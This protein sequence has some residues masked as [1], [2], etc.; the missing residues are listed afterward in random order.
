MKAPIYLF[1]V[2]F[3]FCE[4]LLSQNQ[5]NFITDNPPRVK[6]YSSYLIGN[7]VY[8][9]CDQNIVFKTPDAGESFE[10]LSPYGPVNNSSLGCCDKH[11][12]AFAD[13][14]I[15]Y[16]TDAAHG[17]FRTVDGGRT[18]SKKAHSGSN[19]SL[20][21]FGSTAVGWKVGEGGLYKTTNAG[22][23]WD[24]IGA[25]FFGAGIF[26]NI[27][28]LDNQNVWILK[29]YYR[30]RNVEGSIWYSS[31]GGSTWSQ[32]QSGLVSSDENQIVYNDM[33]MKSS[34]EGIAIGRISRPS[35]NEKRSFIQRTT[36]FGATW[37]TTELPDN[38]LND[39]LY[40]DDSTWVILGNTGNHP[41]NDLV[42]LR[43]EDNGQSWDESIP[44]SYS[45]YNYLYSSIY[46]PGYESILV[47]TLSG[48]YKS[49][50]KGRTYFRITTDYDIYI[51][52]VLL[53][54]KPLSNE[55]QTIIAKSFNR[56]YLLSRDAGRS[57]ELKEIPGEI[58]NI[59][60]KVKIAEEVIYI[61]VDQTRLYKSI[62]YG[63]TWSR[64]YVPLYWS[65]LRAL[66]VLDQNTLLVQGYPSLCTSFDGGANWIASPFP[67]SFWL[68]E[69]VIL[70]SNQIVAVGG[71]YKSGT[72]GIFYKSPDNGF[73]WRIED[74]PHEM[75]QIS[76]ITSKVGFA[77]NAR[78]LYKTIDGGD[79]WMMIKTSNDYYD[80]FSA[81]CFKDAL[82]GLLYSGES[83]LRT[84]DGG[85]NWQTVELNFPFSYVDKLAVNNQGDLFA[86][87]GG[88]F[89]VY[90][91]SGLLKGKADSANT[92]KTLANQFVLLQNTPNPFNIET[93]IPLFVSREG[94]V[95]L[96]IYDILG[97]KVRA[98]FSGFL[99]SGKHYF[100]W[101]GVDDSGFELSSGIYIYRVTYNEGSSFAK[102]MILIK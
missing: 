4:S 78:N 17:E 75:E 53:D 2:I 7:T 59:L 39:V 69:S 62:D 41:D 56:S 29:S 49:I 92:S 64:V 86:V 10:V 80:A 97:Q 88:N 82:N 23:S 65:A 11:G 98:L 79:S 58:G 95:T 16:I 46:L 27:Y 22:E 8:F 52:D 83:F 87:S 66:D 67:G 42:Q 60:W 61:V 96:K 15:G 99:N 93:R 89:L 91:S 48:I 19:I 37:T 84:Q 45:G 90:P 36:D 50:D 40:I 81:F 28:A 12:I 1:L 68:N 100:K 31:D 34:G 51:K 33:L 38:N 26:S 47:N 30:G 25:P 3:L 70:D 20:V 74:T 5:W 32:L 71:F 63:E 13:S 73:N 35:L 94:R 18:W 43:S 76:M 24:F 14:L 57:W 101:D 72:Q 77:L 54:K 44:F 6:V 55:S 9:W 85:V 21:E 102:R